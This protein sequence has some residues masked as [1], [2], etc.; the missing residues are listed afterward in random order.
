MTRASIRAGIVRD[1]PALINVFERIAGPDQAVLDLH[2]EGAG[3]DGNATRADR[4][5]QFVSRIGTTVHAKAKQAAGAKNYP[6]KLLVEG[7][8]PGSV[9]VVFRAP[10]PEMPEGQYAESIVASTVDSDA[11]RLIASIIGNADDISED[12]VIAGKIQELPPKG[13]NALRKAMEGVQTAGWEL[14]GSISQRGFGYSALTL[15]TQGAA[16]LSKE[17]GSAEPTTR[18]ET[19]YGSITGSKDI[20]GLFWFEPDGGREFR[21]VADDPELRRTIV[22]LQLDHP[23]VRADFLVFE[24]HSADGETTSRSRTLQRIERAVATHQ[25]AL[26]DADD[27]GSS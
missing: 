3:V 2:L 12:S 17:L 9:R 23:R 24:T 1:D 8:G 18:P 20:E 5:A 15:T 13:R 14:T 26:D 25:A 21:A 16:R 11:L 19:L 22:E 4:F 7:A 6:H 10:D 27:G